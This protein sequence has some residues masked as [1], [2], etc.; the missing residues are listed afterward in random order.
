MTLCAGVGEGCIHMPGRA[1]TCQPAADVLHVG[2]L[3]PCWTP[4]P[5][6]A[7]AGNC[8]CPQPD[9]LRAACAPPFHTP[10]THTTTRRTFCAHQQDDELRRWLQHPELCPVCL[11]C[12]VLGPYRA[13]LRHVWGV[14]DEGELRHLSGRWEGCPCTAANVPHVKRWVA[15]H[16]APHCRGARQQ[17]G[18]PLD[19]GCWGRAHLVGERGGAVGTDWHPPAPLSSRVE[20]GRWGLGLGLGCVARLR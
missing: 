5:S 4:P 17:A 13:A 2:H 11:P 15:H 14:Q 12:G 20:S 19:G 18:W 16:I 8:E 7:H 1:A 10:R 6:G 3:G 9:V